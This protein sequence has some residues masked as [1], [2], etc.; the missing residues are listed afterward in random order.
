MFRSERRSCRFKTSF[1]AAEGGGEQKGSLASSEAK[2]NLTNASSSS[3]V[4][5]RGAIIRSQSKEGK[6]KMSKGL[7]SS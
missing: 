2:R 1:S 4:S 6:A 7:K 3:R 5:N